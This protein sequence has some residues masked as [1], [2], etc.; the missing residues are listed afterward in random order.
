MTF[1]RIWVKKGLNLSEKM[2]TNG[3]TVEI[4]ANVG[5]A[6][7]SCSPKAALSSLPDV[8]NFYHTGK[9]FYLGNVVLVFRLVK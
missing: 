8:I 1:P 6:F 2:A 3:R 7:A 9:R 4:G 5:G